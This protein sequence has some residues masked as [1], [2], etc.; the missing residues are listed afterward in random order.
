AVLE[1]VLEDGDRFEV[2]GEHP[3]YRP[4][5]GGFRPAAE[6]RPGAELQ[7]ATGQRVRVRAVAPA[8]AT[9]RVY[10]LSVTGPRTY[11]AGGVLVHNY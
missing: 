1:I 7:R 3:L 8:D 5:L 10:N 4:A 11:F 9:A 6:L 2:T